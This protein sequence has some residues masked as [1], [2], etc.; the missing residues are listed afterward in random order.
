MQF[1][2]LRILSYYHDRDLCVLQELPV[3]PRDDS[4]DQDDPVHRIILK[5]LQVCDFLIRSLSVLASS[6]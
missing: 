3:F 2:I 1:G 4:P 6:I 5:Q